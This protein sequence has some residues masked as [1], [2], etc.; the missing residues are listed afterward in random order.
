MLEL[1]LI[2]VMKLSILCG[3]WKNCA[4]QQQPQHQ[5][6]LNGVNW[7]GKEFV[8]KRLGKII[9]A[10]W[11]QLIEVANLAL[12]KSHARVYDLDVVWRRFFIDSIHFDVWWGCWLE[13]SGMMV[14]KLMWEE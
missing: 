13:L 4:W 3:C 6:I 7:S 10:F 2:F 12:M 8:V 5:L 11:T 9:E 1:R 14:L